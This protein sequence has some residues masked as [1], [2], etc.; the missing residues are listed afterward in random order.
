MVNNATGCVNDDLT[1]D[2][3]VDPLPTFTVNPFEIICLN[4]LPLTLEIQSSSSVYDYTWEDDQGTVFNGE[5]IQIR[6]GGT[7]LVTAMTTDGSD[8]SRTEEILVQESSI[9]SITRDDITIV[10][11]SDNNSITID[12][13]NLGIGDYEYAIQNDSGFETPFQDE[14]FFENLDGGIYTIFVRDKNNCGTTSIAVP[15]VEFPKF[16]TPNNDSRNDTWKAKGLSSR[17]FPDSQI[18]IFNRY[19]KQLAELDIDGEGWNGLFNSRPV[20]SDDYWYLVKIVI[21]N[22]PSEER[23]GHFSLLRK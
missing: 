5:E 16:F 20:P 9:A 11:D 21:P 4:D 2:L 17:F 12:P 15:V 18:F 14:P 10:D 6:R 13:T 19:G 8:C 23:Q 22:G 1:F 7:Y 3:N